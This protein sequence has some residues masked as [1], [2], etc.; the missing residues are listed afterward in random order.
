MNIQ[1][2][3]E[4]L[5]Q[6]SFHELSPWS[7]G[8][9]SQVLLSNGGMGRTGHFSQSQGRGSIWVPSDYPTAGCFRSIT[10]GD[11]PGLPIHRNSICKEF[12][13]LP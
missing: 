4:G 5:G 8:V 3:L 1:Q 7:S 9:C 11:L 10:P 13:A 6:I 2:Y 12:T